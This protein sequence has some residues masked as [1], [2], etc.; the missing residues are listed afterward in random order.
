[1][2]NKFEARF[3]YEDSHLV[4]MMY[5]TELTQL[6]GQVL[7]RHAHED[8]SYYKEDIPHP[9][10]MGFRKDLGEPRGQIADYRVTL[11]DGRS[12]HARE[13][14]ESW[15]VHWDRM[16]WTVDA[17]EHL[18]LDSPGYYA[19]VCTLVGCGI[20]AVVGAV[21][22]GK[23]GAVLGAVL[24]ALLGCLFALLTVEWDS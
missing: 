22:K 17:V 4:M 3:I 7:R 11:E 5:R 19:L 2:Y 21:A 12:V 23:R 13:Y 24:G 14:R 20:G 18:R 1:M 6:V 10:S 8:V 9:L 16:D 15:R